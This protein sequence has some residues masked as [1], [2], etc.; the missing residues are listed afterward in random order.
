MNVDDCCKVNNDPIAL[1]CPVHLLRLS[2]VLG[3]MRNIERVERPKPVE[4]K[5]ETKYTLNTK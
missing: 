1:L 4:N 2:H 3:W 5:N